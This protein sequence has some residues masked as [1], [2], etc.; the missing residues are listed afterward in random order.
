MTAIDSSRLRILLDPPASGVW[1]M[2]VDEALLHSSEFAGLTLRFYQWNEPTLSL[3]YFQS[4]TDRELHPRSSNCPV[5][6]RA[7][8]GGAIL[9]D[10][11]LTYSLV[12][13]V[14]Q[15]FGDSAAELYDIVHLSLCDTLS[16]WGVSATMY[17]PPLVQLGTPA[18]P[19]PHPPEPF[20][21]FNRRSRGDVVLGAHKICG[22]AQRRHQQRVLQHGSLLL[23][24]S[25]AAPELP[26]VVEL[27]PSPPTLDEVSRTWIRH[28]V[29]RLQSLAPLHPHE[30]TLTS[31]ELAAARIHEG[32]FRDP[33]WTGKR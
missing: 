27:V 23:A 14:S 17:E 16:E 33:K 29:R 32:K 9:H 28:L 7:S 5:V 2:A 13:P 21:C 3:G 1:N 18:V 4:L 31:G 24:R 15:R 11:E 30:S 19:V 20:L 25:L 26:G 22:S 8:G 12:A 10:R 6:R